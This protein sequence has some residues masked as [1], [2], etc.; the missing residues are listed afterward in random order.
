MNPLLSDDDDDSSSYLE[1]NESSKNLELSQNS[2]GNPPRVGVIHDTE[3]VA[4]KLSTVNSTILEN[5]SHSIYRQQAKTALEDSVVFDKQ[6]IIDTIITPNVNSG[7]ILVRFQSIGST[8][9]INPK[10]YRISAKQKVSS[11]MNFVL[12]KLNKTSVYCYIHNSF[13][14]SNDEIVG[15]LFSNFAINNELVVSYCTN[16]AFG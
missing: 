9:Q 5:L 12:K 15:N 10:V 2:L 7:K 11:L 16:V 6:Q 14:P 8:Q 3:E 4:T 13:S 1:S